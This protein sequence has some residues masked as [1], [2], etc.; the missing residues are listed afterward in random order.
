MRRIGFAVLFALVWAEQASA[1]LLGD[2]SGSAPQESWLPDWAQVFLGWVVRQQAEFGQ[3]LRQ[4]V[5]AYR[6]SGALE[7]ALALIGLSFAYGVFHAV[8]PGHGKAVVS[9]YFMARDSA[10]KRG[11]A[12]GWAIAAV[13]ALVAIALVGVLG[14]A[15][16][17]SRLALLDSMPVVEAGSYALV[18][19]LGAGLLWNSLRVGHSHA[20]SHDH[21]HDH[22]ACGHD[23]G[24]PSE[25]LPESRWEFAAA[26]IT[27]GIRPCTGSL[28]V[29]LFALANGIF[30]IGVL[31]AVAMGVGVALTI[32][33]VG[34]AAILSRRGL[35]RLG[36]AAGFAGG[37]AALLPRAL[38]VLGSAAVMLIGVILL[39]GTLAQG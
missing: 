17:F 34:I 7:P 28:I 15:L 12:L 19:L 30:F 16:S 27:S 6:D 13:Q 29:L 1:N 33:A 26:A 18:A 20:H 9:S 37:A 22:A 35:L 5:A 24:L 38:S 25:R 11:L 8:G 2:R 39:Y 23:H 3:A 14:W 4:G 10:I 36:G 32:S 21:D 31:S